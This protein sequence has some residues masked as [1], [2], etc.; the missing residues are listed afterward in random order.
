MLL[1]ENGYK[2]S[3]ETRSSLSVSLE[4]ENLLLKDCKEN[5]NKR[6]YYLD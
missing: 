6:D 4:N 3:D 1:K 2:K 5:N